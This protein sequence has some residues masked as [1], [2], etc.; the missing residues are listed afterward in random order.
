[1]NCDRDLCYSQ[2]YVKDGGCHQCKAGDISQRI[3][4]DEELYGVDEVA[5]ENTK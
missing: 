1:M 2:D 3:S 4:E 5:V